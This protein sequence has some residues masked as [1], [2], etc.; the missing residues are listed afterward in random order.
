MLDV[1][2]HLPFSSM[3][4]MDDDPMLVGLVDLHTISLFTSVLARG[5]H[6]GHS[7]ISPQALESQYVCRTI[8]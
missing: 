4:H 6:R 2:L 3:L 5:H 8:V 7:R 1:V